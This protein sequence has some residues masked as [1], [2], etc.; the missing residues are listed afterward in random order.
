[1]Q[2]EKKYWEAYLN[3]DDADAF[4]QF[5]EYINMKDMR[6]GITSDKGFAKQ[7]ELVG[8]TE[9]ISNAQLP[10]ANNI[11]IGV[12]HDYANRR[13]I[14]FTTS[15][16]HIDRIF[17]Y[18][19]IGDIVYVV[20]KGEDVTGGLNFDKD[21]LIHSARVEN[22][23][24]YWT[25]NLNEPRRIN[26]NAGIHTYQSAYT[27]VDPYTIP[28]ARS[29]VSWI[30]R[31]PGLPPNELKVQ[32][33][34][35]VVAANQIANEAFTFAYRYV[36]RDF[37]LST[38]SGQSLL[39]NY[40]AEGSLYNAIDITIP[41]GEH[42]EQDVIQVD[43]VARYMVS[44]IF[45]VI[46]SWD[47]NIPA[48]AA[49]IAAHNAGTTALTY[50]FY[51]D[52]AGIALD[53]SYSNK[54][55]DSVPL[56]C[57]T[58]EMAKSRAFLGNY[59]IGYDTPITTSLA[60][61]TSSITFT[62]SGAS[63]T[64]EWFL[65]HYQTIAPN[66][67]GSAYLLYTTHNFGGNPPTGTYWYTWNAGTVPPFPASVNF[68]DLTYRGATFTQMVNSF[69]G[70][71]I[72]IAPTG[73][74]DQ[75]ASS[76]IVSGTTPPSPVVGN[77]FKSNAAYQ[78]S[79]SFKDFAGRECGILSNSTL[80]LQTPDTGLSANTYINAINWTLSNSNALAEIPDWAY[81]YSINITKCL[82][83]RFFLQSLGV[84]IYAGKDTN[85]L[86]TFTTTTYSSDLVGVAIDL[87]FLTTHAQG[88]VFAQGDTVELYVNGALYNLSIIAQSAQWIICQLVDVG[89]LSA[90][91]GLFE[92]YTPYQRQANEPYFEVAQIYAVNNP[93]TSSRAYSALTGVITGD[94]YIFQRINS[95][96][97]YFTEG[98]SDNDKFY[99]N[100]FTNSGRPDFVDHIGQVSKP[101]SIAY[102]NT[103]IPGSQNNGLS[104]FDALDTSD[105]SPDFGPISKLQLSSKVSKIGTVMLAICSGPTTASI[106]LGEN[107]LISQTGDAVIA[108]ANTVIGS[109][110]ELKGD[111]GT[112]NPESVVELR[113][114]IYWFDAQNEKV[115]QYADNG[116]FPI[117]KY[118]L[119]RFWKLFSDQYKSLTAAQ[120]EALGSRPFVFG[121]ADPHH[122]EIL[123]TVPRTL[124][125]PPLG[126]LPDD[127]STP[128]PFDIWD[129]Q[130]KTLVYKL[131]P[132]PNR[133]QGS[134][135][136]QAEYMFY[137]ENN[138]FSFKEGQL[139]R[140]NSS[141]I[142]CNYYGVQYTPAVMD[143]SNQQ[144]NKPKVYNNFSVE[145][146]TPPSR[147]YFMTRYPF[148]QASDLVTSDFAEKEGVWY[149]TIYRNKLDPAFT[150]PEQAL[151]AGEKMRT[152]ALYIMTQWDAT[153]GLV[154]AKFLNIGYTVSL[155]QPV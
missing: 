57:E 95:S 107:T 7:L 130:G 85:N 56:G 132:Q 96:I 73:Y 114:D 55:F 78:L 62:G 4:I 14:Y 140:H 32:Q 136:F 30:R 89:S 150:S 53:T 98:M 80:L 76:I 6:F 65:L 127:P 86:Y 23:C 43:L 139:Y 138:L 70:G 12:A 37:E 105:L 36:Y 66:F 26:I 25:D 17:C 64:G 148:I 41:L 67:A 101:T 129:G 149:A 104:T 134:Y 13:I 58:L 91:T 45:F 94:V 34:V 49:A 20:L 120:I 124:A 113:G 88:Y 103:F 79:I 151:I 144:L 59:Y 28:I 112:L 39:A 22:G 48:D 108:Q 102:S 100:W 51:N 46:N 146:N 154:Q 11:C 125:D 119:S 68:S 82:R 143:L 10:V 126:Y 133:W 128:Y 122:N 38:L 137:L 75:S 93:G 155:G 110:H 3:A 77:T 116:L 60:F 42:I 118:K 27:D 92:I 87:T 33:T 121:S 71:A 141:V 147:V 16:E 47:K 111:Y 8:G 69:L 123:F 109:I 35:P 54:I 9:V 15:T 145:G 90:T 81:A 135:S 97:T 52:R 74:T 152:T 50:R 63:I 99:L 2:K 21:H 19:Y 61:T 44:G 18:E 31:Q 131:D 40:N 83:T 24:V 142:Y 29:V 1:L 153:Q 106:Y 117:S 115:I 84:I 72:A 5:T